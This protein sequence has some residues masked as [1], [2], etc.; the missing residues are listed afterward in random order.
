MLPQYNPLH[1]IKKFLRTR[2]L[3]LEPRGLNLL[4]ALE[5]MRLAPP[6][7]KARLGIDHAPRLLVIDPPGQDSRP[8][9]QLYLDFLA[10][11]HHGLNT[12]LVVPRKERGTGAQSMGAQVF[13][14]RKNTS[15]T[16]I[17]S[18]RSYNRSRGKTYSNLLFLDTQEYGPYSSLTRDLAPTRWREMY[19]T[20]IS[21]IPMDSPGVVIIHFREKER[22]FATRDK[23]KNLRFSI[24][25]LRDNLLFELPRVFHDADDLACKLKALNAF[26]KSLNKVRA[27]RDIIKSRVDNPCSVSSIRG[28]SQGET[29]RFLPLLESQRFFLKAVA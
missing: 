21:P 18:P 4:S 24:S 14:L 27:T 19:S 17:T 23:I 7:I 29:T 26:I 25:S 22:A 3:D 10:T 11:L 1:Q 20:L 8:I 6:S 16:Y 5:T 2:S 28:L 9:L 12:M 15:R 13:N